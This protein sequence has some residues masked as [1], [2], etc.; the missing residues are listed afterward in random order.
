MTTSDRTPQRHPGRWIAALTL[1]TLGLTA[2]V[3]YLVS[4]QMDVTQQRDHAR[5]RVAEAAAKH[6]RLTQRA[7]IL[8]KR[9]ATLELQNTELRQQLEAAS[10]TSGATSDPSS[11]V[12]LRTLSMPLPDEGTVGLFLD[13]GR[14]S[15]ECCDADFRL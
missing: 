8:T 10:R 14:V 12:V 11:D 4:T 7:A 6:S 2:L 3:I 1:I 9:A 5:R 15:T 13:Q